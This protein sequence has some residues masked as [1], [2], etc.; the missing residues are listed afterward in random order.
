MGGD[1][2]R[3]EDRS[4]LPPLQVLTAPDPE[5]CNPASRAP[6]TVAFLTSIL[7]SPAPSLPVPS[8]P[9]FAS[10][11]TI[12][13]GHLHFSFFF[14]PVSSRIVGLIG[15]SSNPVSGMT[16]AALLLTSLIWVAL[17]LNDGG[18]GAKVAVL[19][20]GAVVCISAAAAG[21]PPAIRP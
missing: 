3:T 10:E 5:S 12:H 2:S 17:G 8:A 7:P 14:V 18:A 15:S 13:D 9:L 20:V 16:I 11:P 6:G 21:E 4:T 1:R 19:A